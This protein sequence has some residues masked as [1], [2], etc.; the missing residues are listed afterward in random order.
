MYPPPNFSH[1]SPTSKV[2]IYII[3]LF[4]LSFL[5]L[6]ILLSDLCE[7]FHIWWYRLAW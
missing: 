2:Y 4:R 5:S 1:A 6:A 3:C 7:P